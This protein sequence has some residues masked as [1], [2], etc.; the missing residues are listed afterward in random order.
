MRRGRV[1]AAAVLL[2]VGLAG[3]ATQDA[4]Y[5][6]A[7]SDALQSGVLT[8]T[9]AAAD[10][11]PEAALARLNELEA[12]LLDALARDAI[13]Q[14]RFDS[15]TAA[16]ALVRAD[17]LLAVDALE[18]EEP[19]VEN[20]GPGNSDKPKPGKPDKPGKPEKD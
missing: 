5:P 15:V 13:N 19:A 17:L 8:V 2:A 18:P 11:D 10:G 14:S 6:P 7:T 1:L 9:Q 16:I 20:T 3:C 4:A 12:A